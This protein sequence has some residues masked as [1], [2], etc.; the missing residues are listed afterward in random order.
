M[1]DELREFAAELKGVLERS[2][3]NAYV[4]DQVLAK[5]RPTL[6]EAKIPRTE[7]DFSDA[8]SDG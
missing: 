2:G 5:Y 7:P 4:V 3:G 6:P 1:G 8:D